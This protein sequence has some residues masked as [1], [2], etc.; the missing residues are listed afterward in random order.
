M[1]FIDSHPIWPF[2]LFYD[3]GR[4]KEA[5]LFKSLAFKELGLLS[6]WVLEAYFMATI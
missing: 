6:V 5:W 4:S 3:K 2:V 1:H